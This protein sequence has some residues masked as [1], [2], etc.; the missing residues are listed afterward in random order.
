MLGKDDKCMEYDARGVC[1]QRAPRRITC[2]ARG[3]S[4]HSPGPVVLVTVAGVLCSRGNTSVE[5]QDGFVQ[6]G[7]DKRACQQDRGGAPLRLRVGHTTL[8]RRYIDLCLCWHACWHARHSSGRHATCACGQPQE[9]R[10]SGARS[11]C[12]KQRCWKTRETRVTQ[13]PP[14]IDVPLRQTAWGFKAEGTVKAQA[15]RVVALRSPL[16]PCAG[17]RTNVFTSVSQ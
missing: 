3:A 1:Q 10:E 14:V 2:A 12:M 7:A 15:A 13:C 4:A 9:A 17:T 16:A 11:C 6:V 5:A 8:M